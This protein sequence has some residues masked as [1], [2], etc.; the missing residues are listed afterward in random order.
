MA[1][2]IPS[3]NTYKKQGQKIRD[4]V[5][6]R[7]EVYSKN[8]VELYNYDEIVYSYSDNSAPLVD[9]NSPKQ[10][11][12][13][14]FAFA[15]DSGTP[16]GVFVYARVDNQKSQNIVL[17]IPIVKGNKY[18]ASIKTGDYE[19]ETTNKKE[20]NIKTSF[21][22]VVREGS[23]TASW[24]WDYS[25]S[26]GF[27]VYYGSINWDFEKEDLKNYT[28]E[29]EITIEKERYG[30]KAKVNLP[31]E[32]IG[33]ISTAKE[34]I[35]SENGID[36]YV[37]ELEIFS[38]YRKCVLGGYPSPQTGKIELTGTVTDFVPYE[39]NI[40]IYGNEIGISLEDKT[41][42]INGETAK[43]VHSVDSNELL[44]VSNYFILPITIKLKGDFE[45]YYTQLESTNR[46]DNP[47]YERAIIN[48]L[49][50]T[51]IGKEIIIK[52]YDTVGGSSWEITRI[53]KDGAV[54]TGKTNNF[55]KLEVFVKNP[56]APAIEY[57]YEKTQKQY[58]NGLETATILCD[59]NDYYSEK[60]RVKVNFYSEINDTIYCSLAVGSEEFADEW[61]GKYIYCDGIKGFVQD[62]DENNLIV[63]FY[64]T[65][66]AEK[67]ESGEIEIYYK[68]IAVDNSTR[69]MSFGI[70]DKVIPMVLGADG[71]DR[72]ISLYQDGTPKVFQVLG[73]KTHY[74]GAVWQ[75]LSL[76]EV[77]QNK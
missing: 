46:D 64:S 48:F 61:N 37:L 8:A 60:V 76:Q 54:D 20:H 33:N 25:I 55:N 19:D 5:I 47:P 32:D 11:S 57:L 9:K 50:G 73:K 2:L 34:T 29:K 66:I 63:S 6:E 39:V 67:L 30:Y 45:D 74:D 13:M 10:K 31:I 26:N 42:Y 51:H 15:D 14:D 52:L 28:V 17:K 65:A 72:P 68:E 71:K 53:N 1:V 38:S 16:M 4:N 41:I 75:E 56:S 44:Q 23:A 12:D 21:N 59:I 22:G 36:Y 40:N 69:K 7:I 62:Y 3:K 24:N 58:Q 70:Y 35:V 49:Q 18:I 77:A 27:T 43:K